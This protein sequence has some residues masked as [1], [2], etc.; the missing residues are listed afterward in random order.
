MRD[1]TQKDPE[2]RPSATAVLNEYIKS[3]VNN[4]IT[5]IILEL[6]LKILS[7]GTCSENSELRGLA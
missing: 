7:I 1:L 3:N 2:A 4:Y 5:T 6:F